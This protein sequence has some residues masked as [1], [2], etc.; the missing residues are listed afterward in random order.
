MKRVLEMC[1]QATKQT[2][3]KETK[4]EGDT[5]IIEYKTVDQLIKEYISNNKSHQVISQL[6]I[7]L[8]L[9]VARL[10]SDNVYIFKLEDGEQEF[11]TSDNPVILQHP[12][13]EQI[14]PFDPSNIMKLPL[15]TKHYLMLM[16]NND[17][18]KLNRIVRHNASGGFSR[19]EELISN[20][21]QLQ[22]ANEYILGSISS[23][24]RYLNIKEKDIP[25]TDEEQALLDRLIELGKKLWLVQFKTMIV[26]KNERTIEKNFGRY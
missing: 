20:T 7:A 23:L 17:K 19:R 11:I 10:K 1:I 5:Y 9:V 16:P 21:E 25:L 2:G 12:S 3:Q 18:S 15:D 8:K 24:T 4:I 6:N 22:G 26:I 14:F 13:N